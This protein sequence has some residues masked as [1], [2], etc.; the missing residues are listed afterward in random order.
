[1]KIDLKRFNAYTIVRDLLF[2][3]WVIV[4]AVVTGFVGGVCYY[5]FLHTETYVSSMTV[6]INLS[7]YTSEAAALSLAR[8]VVIAE[9]L[10]DVFQS[11]ALRDVVEKDLGESLTGSMEARQ[12][13]ETNLV[14]ITVT[15][16]SPEKA[17]ETLVSVYKNYYK[18]TDFAFSNV[19]IRT[20]VNPEMPL[21]PTNRVTPIA[22]G[23]LFGILAGV[24]V[25]G[26]IAV[27]SFLRD[28]VKNVSDI[29]SELD[30]KLFATVNSVKRLS[31]NLPLD[32]H[33]LV[34]T[35]PLIPP[36]F[37][38]SFR[39]IAVKLE[40]L[41]RIK[42][43]KSVMITSVTENEGKTS[44]AVNTAMTLAE[45]GHRVLLLD[46]DFKNPSD[47]HFFDEVKNP[48]ETDFRNYFRG[49]D[50][51]SGFI[52]QDP[53][54]GLFILGNARAYSDSAELLG[55]SQFKAVLKELKEMFDFIIIDTPPCGITVD[56]E[57]LSNSVDASLL[58]IRQ[59]VVVVKDINA[60]IETLAHG[61]V[62]GCVFND[63][64]AFGRKDGG[65][66]INRL[67]KAK[68][69]EA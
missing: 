61:N 57:V 17:Y 4:L 3:A 53:I 43:I 64:S 20:V 49:T 65:R 39:K 55:S 24:I 38:A 33:R 63:V 7:G 25:A 69:G 50:A 15:D 59:D 16:N 10:D 5:S 47:Y 21:Q 45:N 41:H 62:I 29:E 8:T 2:N 22:G 42:G 6:S 66:N 40:S 58:V 23:V 27:I 19:I 54:T 48:E 13:E 67:D 28:T 56:A 32:K 44:V 14:S 26:I 18:V 37:A 52:K 31:R 9:N 11:K 68:K 34:V 60:Q 30:T 36:H 35:N 46:A 51:L 1:M 12:I